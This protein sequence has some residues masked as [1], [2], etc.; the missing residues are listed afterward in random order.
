MGSPGNQRI[1]ANRVALA[2]CLLLVAWVVFLLFPRQKPEPE[3]PVQ[4]E[5]KLRA[6]GLPDNVDLEGLPE[7]FAAWADTKEVTW[8][9]DHASFGYWNPVRKDYSYFIEVTRTP[10]GYRFS[11]REDVK[12]LTHI[13]PGPSSVESEGKEQLDPRYGGGEKSPTHP[14][15]FSDPQIP[16][17]PPGTPSWPVPEQKSMPVGKPEKVSI[18]IK[19]DSPLQIPQPTLKTEDSSGKK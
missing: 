19:P 1:P 18:E 8:F 5:S 16:N 15:D 7:F 2:F 3:A 17:I 4:A 12:N 11:L 9:D 6:V 10:N 13:L 14:F